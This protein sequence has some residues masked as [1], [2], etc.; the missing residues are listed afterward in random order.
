M[1]LIVQLCALALSLITKLEALRCNYGYRSLV[2][3]TVYHCNLC[4]NIQ[5]MQELV[6]ALLHSYAYCHAFHSIESFKRLCLLGV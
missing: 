4:F 6:T 5:C 1:M 3:R 2:E